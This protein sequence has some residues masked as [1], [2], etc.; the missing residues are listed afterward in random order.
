MHSR[1]CAVTPCTA[2]AASVAAAAAA[3]AAATHSCD[4]QRLHDFQP[5]AV[6]AVGLPASVMG[7][8][9]ACL[10]SHALGGVPFIDIYGNALLTGPS[11]V[12]QV[13]KSALRHVF[14]LL[15]CY[16]HL[17]DGVPFINVSSPAL[18]TRPSSMYQTYTA[19]LCCDVTARVL[20]ST[21]HAY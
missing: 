8:N 16:K 3:A 2:A 19:S 18:L 20:H 6:M 5:D 4:S 11:R 9:L 15:H 12:P 1:Q 13:C 10:L 17:Q 21:L 7:D 14:L